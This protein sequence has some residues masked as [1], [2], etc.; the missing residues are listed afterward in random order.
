M[1]LV[2]SPAA[3][4]AAPPVASDPAVAVQIEQWLNRQGYSFAYGEKSARALLGDFY[5]GANE[6]VGLNLTP[7][8]S[9]DRS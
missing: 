9:V 6:V 5:L 7:L 2:S 3:L 8:G 1:F 4:P